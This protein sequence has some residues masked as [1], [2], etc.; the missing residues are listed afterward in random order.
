MA[1][2]GTPNLPDQCNKNNQNPFFLKKTLIQLEIQKRTSE[3]YCKF[4]TRVNKLEEKINE[5]ELC[6]SFVIYGMFG[7]ALSRTVS[8]SPKIGAKPGE[9][10]SQIKLGR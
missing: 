9:A 2:K 6:S 3:R 5:L 7:I 10:F 8:A 4:T 1:V